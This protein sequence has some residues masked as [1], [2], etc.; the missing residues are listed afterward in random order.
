V[1]SL[2]QVK[3]WIERSKTGDF[4]FQ[5][6]SRTSP[7]SFG[8]GE[9]LRNLLNL[10]KEFPFALCMIL[11]GMLIT[12]TGTVTRA[13]RDDLGLRQCTRQWTPDNLTEA[14]KVEC[15]RV[16]RCLLESLRLAQDTEFKGFVAGDR[17]WV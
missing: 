16:S 4:S 5:D 3:E 12:S 2:T 7:P 10:P 6:H 17:P 14:Q 15:R 9:P 11:A 13:L 8:L 1:C